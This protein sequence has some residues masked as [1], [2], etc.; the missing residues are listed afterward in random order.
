MLNEMRLGV[1]EVVYSIGHVIDTYQM[2]VV[3][4]I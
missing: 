2:D 1:E 4:F 3:I